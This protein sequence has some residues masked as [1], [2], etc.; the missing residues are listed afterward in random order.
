[1]S[2]VCKAGNTH[3]LWPTEAFW[4]DC[5]DEGPQTPSNSSQQHLCVFSPAGW[6]SCCGVRR[7]LWVTGKKFETRAELNHLLGS[8]CH[9]QLSLSNKPMWV[10]FI[11]RKATHQSFTLYPTLE[12]LLWASRRWEEV[13]QCVWCMFPLQK[14]SGAHLVMTIF[15]LAY[16]FWL[17]TYHLA[18]MVKLGSWMN[19]TW[20]KPEDFLFSL[21]IPDMLFHQQLSGQLPARAWVNSRVALDHL[22]LP[23]LSSV[24]SLCGRKDLSEDP[25]IISNA[26]HWNL[27]H[28]LVQPSIQYLPPMDNVPSTPALS[29][30]PTPVGWPVHVCATVTATSP[31]L[32]WAANYLLIVSA[33]WSLFYHH[34]CLPGSS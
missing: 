34:N 32:F 12:H 11:P 19:E 23:P 30:P 1:M 4:A 20:P 10:T 28:C 21:L 33:H 7:K 2:L 9:W 6:P 17:L 25:R 15:L 31:S 5:T 24:S 13:G 16:T 27:K 18:K 3:T 26:F 14:P 8:V 29:Q 22:W